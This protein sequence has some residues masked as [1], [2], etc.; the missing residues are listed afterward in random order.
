MLRARLEPIITGLITSAKL[1]DF[2]RAIKARRRGAARAVIEYFHQ[3]DDPYSHLAAQVLEPLRAAFDI[4]L[5]VHLVAPPAADAAPD[6]VRLQAYARRD[7]AMLARAHG[8]DFPDEFSQPTAATGGLPFR[9]DTPLDVALAEG[10]ARR[11][12]LG[13]Y[14]GAMFHFEGEWYWGIDRLPHLAARLA[15]NGLSRPGVAPALPAQLHETGATTVSGR[16]LRLD[17]FA[18]LRSPYTYLAAARARRL[19][20]A[21]G[22]EFRIRYV[23]PMVMRGLPVPRAKRLYIV[24]DAK[25]EAERL[26]LPFGRIKDP[27]GKGV[28]RGLAVLAGAIALGKGAA[29][30]ESFLAGAFAEGIDAT[31]DRGLT[32]LAAR[33]GLSAADVAAALKDETWRQVADSNR[34][35]LLD[36]GLWGVP[37]FRVND[38]PAHWGQDRLW[39]IENDLRAFGGQA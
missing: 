14:L 26:G 29:F 31:T 12:K 6:A 37:S 33:A 22:A 38:G 20:E 35:E 2:R 23:L 3:P 28:E 18:S 24:L 11:A 17:F 9:V 8:L 39:A 34:Q 5:R 13:H 16:K 4:D 15:A 10:T 25:R 21:Y 7:A 27:V 19:A 32:M 30:L 1:R 36:L